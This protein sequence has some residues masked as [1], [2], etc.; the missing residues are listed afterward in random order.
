MPL[1]GLCGLCLLAHS[2]NALTL[3]DTLTPSDALTLT[4][5]WT[6]PRLLPRDCGGVRNSSSG[7]DSFAEGDGERA[8]DEAG[9]F[10]EG[11]SERGGEGDSESGEGRTE[12]LALL[13]CGELGTSSS[14]LFAK[15]GWV[16][17]CD[18]WLLARSSAKRRLMAQANWVGAERLLANCPSDLRWDGYEL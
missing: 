7:G 15:A 1:S 17:V 3:S 13:G 6:L 5:P 2:P 9:G 8:I 4:D 16:P 14:V 12:G 11:D 10:A 18:S